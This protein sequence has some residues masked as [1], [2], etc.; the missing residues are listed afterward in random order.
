MGLRGSGKSAVGRLLAK[1][2]NRP[3]VDLDARVLAT[4]DEPTVTAVWSVH[5]EPAWRAAETSVLGALLGQSAGVIALGGGTPMI[6]AARCDIEA[7]RVSGTATVIYLR[8]DAAELQRR[9][10]AQT[11]DR[12]S[13]TGAD[14]VQETTIVM[15][16]REPIYRRLADHEYDVTATPPERV[17]QELRKLFE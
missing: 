10:A 13:L 6:D 5:G 16:T 1:Q 4:F 2:L 14:A 9:L 7:A 11:G 15:Q 3:F 12:P 17:A 8:C